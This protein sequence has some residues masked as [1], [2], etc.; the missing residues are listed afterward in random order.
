VRSCLLAG[1]HRGAIQT[2]SSK[3]KLVSKSSTESELIACSD[4]LNNVIM[5]RNFLIELGYDL[6]P[7]TVFQDNLSTL[8][9]I[10]HGRPASERTRHVAVRF[11]FIKDRVDSKEI[12]VEYCP[13]GDMIADVLTKPLQGSQFFKLRSLLLNTPGNVDCRGVMEIQEF[14]SPVPASFTEV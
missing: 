13:T 14:Q 4:A 10:E 5:I 1:V 9:L 8:K 11:F 2:K 3:Q 7:A 12:R 6:G